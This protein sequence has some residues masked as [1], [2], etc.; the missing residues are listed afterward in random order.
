MEKNLGIKWYQT[1][2]STNSQANRELADAPHGS[3]WVA[4]FQTAGRGQRGNKWESKAA[5]NLTFT[6]LLRPA[7]LHPSQQFLISQIA[8]LGVL[9]YLNSKGLE[10]KIKWPNDI[11]IG[12]RK[13]CGMLIENSI[14][15]D[16]MSASIVGIGLNLNQRE[17]SSDAPNPTSLLLE[18][19]IPANTCPT[20]GKSGD[21]GDSGTSGNSGNV[22]PLQKSYNRREELSTLLG[23]IFTAYSELEEGCAQELGQEYL[24]NLYRLGEWPQF[25]EIDSNAPADMPVEKMAAGR[26]ITAR[27]TGVDP[28]GCV[29]LEHQDGTMQTY[30]FKGIRYIL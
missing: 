6:I 22:V 20:P 26:T 29:I 13:I 23:Y 5:E 15:A 3:V 28:Y 17:F 27:I 24:A 1:I 21:A 10:A 7:F 25:I 12:N 14:S 9:R 8:S 11:Y 18:T 2:D 16:K 4:D 30:P 19:D